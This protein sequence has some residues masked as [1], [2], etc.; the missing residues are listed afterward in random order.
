M[1]KLNSFCFL[2]RFG[3]QYGDCGMR[4]MIR[5]FIAS[6]LAVT[7]ISSDVL[8]AERFEK[9]INSNW[10]TEFWFT[11]PPALIESGTTDGYF[12]KVYVNSDQISNVTISVPGKGFS[13]SA[14]I[15]PGLVHEFNLEPSA[16]QP[17]IKGALDPVF[18]SD[19]YKNSAINI[20]SDNPVTVHAV[21]R[22][23][24]ISEGF[25]VLPVNVLGKEYIVSSSGDKSVYYPPYNSFP[26]LSG[27]VA[28]FDGTE[29]NFTLGGNSSTV[30]SSGQIPGET[31]KKLLNKGDVW[32]LSSKGR[33]A[34][35]TGSR[36]VSTKPVAVVSG[37]HAA[38]VPSSKNDHFGYVVEM[39]IPTFSWA[40]NY[41]VPQIYT[42][43]YSPVI[44][45]FAKE[46]N[47]SIYLNG[48]LYS[49][50]TLSDGTLGKGYL[51]LRMNDV[52][53]LKS[54][55]ISSDKPIAVTL[56]NTGVE[57]DGLPEPPG[58]P[59]QMTLTPAEQYVNE[60]YFAAPALNTADSYQHNYVNIIYQKDDGGNIP[61]DLQIGKYD[62]SDYV[63]RQVKSTAIL[64]NEDFP[65][66]NYGLLAIKIEPTGN[67]TIKS[68]TKFTA[69]MFGFNKENSYGFPAALKIA[70]LADE[71]KIPPAVNWTIDCNGNVEGTT[72]DMPDDNI[73]RS[74]L[75][76]SLY[77]SD[78]SNNFIK[79]SFNPIT[80][81]ET[82][83]IEW[84]LRVVDKDKDAN[85]VILFWDF[86][87]NSTKTNI[88]YKASNTEINSRYENYGAFNVSSE[89]VSKE[90]SIVNNSDSSFQI[91]NIELKE[92]TAG[93]EL[94]E[95]P[96]LPFTLIKGGAVKFKA[97]FTPAES[98]SFTDSIGYGND[99]RFLYVSHLE[100]TVGS[101]VIEVTDVDFGDVTIGGTTSANAFITNTGVSELKLTGYK[102]PVNTDFEVTFDKVFDSNNPLILLPGEKTRLSVKF[103]PGKISKYIDSVVILSDA[104]TRD[105]I[106]LIN[107]RSIE[108]GLAATSYNWGR[109]RIFRTYYPAGPYPIA[110]DNQSIILQ[111]TGNTEIVINGIQV[112]GEIHS[113]AFEF[114]RQVFTNLKIAAGGK[115]EYKVQFRPVQP[116]NHN[117]LIKY[118]NDF[119]STT[120]TELKGFGTLPKVIS[121]VVDFDTAIAGNY[122]APA[123]RKT[124]ITNLSYEDWEYADSL[125]IYDLF[126]PNDESISEVWANYGS[127][128]F[129]IDKQVIPFPIKLAPGKSHLLYSGFVPP[130]E[131][132]SLAEVKVISDA[133]DTA[134]ISLRGVGIDQAMTF[135]GGTAEACIGFEKI[136]KG[137]IKNNST[138]D[139]KIAKVTIINP[140]P[141]FTILNNDIY[142]GFT[143]APGDLKYLD[144]L[145]KPGSLA[146]KQIEIE[147]TDARSQGLKKQALFSGKPVRYPSD[148]ILSPASQAADIGDTI[149][150]RIMFRTDNDL[151][152]LKLTELEVSI[153]YN[154]HILKP[155][156][157]SVQIGGD[158]EGSFIIQRDT[159]FK[160]P[161]VE[162]YIIKSIAGIEISRDINLFGISF[163]VY[164]PND[165]IDYTDIEV[166]ISPVNNECIVVN[167]SKARVVINPVCAND[168][169]VIRLTSTKYYL[170]E[171]APNPITNTFAEINFG[172]GISAHTELKIFS[173]IGEEIAA[174]VNSYLPS[175]EYSVMLN[176]VNLHSGIYFYVIKSGPFYE[177]KKFMISK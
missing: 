58:D 164:F 20:K 62:G 177:T 138:K 87:G 103:S 10:G 118:L 45:I 24:K 173:G 49:N 124:E 70:T 32:M 135:T 43:K 176:T 18:P 42:R 132:L 162:K 108:P 82:K 54:G 16:A 79:G 80:P 4:N 48:T 105:N 75:D 55:T 111:N 91:A 150:K 122:D 1:Q 156:S 6:F 25:T 14:V 23:N 31:R 19:I 83:S 46:P 36:I 137:I 158:L 35:L 142:D 157:G 76:A 123:V 88:I 146:D 107:A 85:A 33:D 17:Y 63:F 169:R 97:R 86:A 78:E 64:L 160:S 136:I 154:E 34:D 109:K 148:I 115:F 106:C 7:V 143:L 71:D 37:N 28:A 29:V 68:D 129:K 120:V 59:F 90:F 95:L 13:Q 72:I 112:E 53:S 161:G 152:G 126:T 52:S 51:E 56:Y 133:V 61:D 5:L 104:V 41:H 21:V 38:N 119:G 8:S 175:G 89:P 39:E 73:V 168:L 139:I 174:P 153:K 171:T 69:Y 159:D 100:A 77:L 128:G 172:I 30:T 101:P 144:V 125:T 141:E 67:Y 47:T 93:F 81:G 166:E 110:N 99:C 74:N 155:I 163:T 94:I 116:G 60:I 9:Y 96:N 12:V 114:N 130:V 15:K 117:L 167:S 147:L 84:S 65:G 140:E 102:N 113:D 149:S 2:H 11:V 131:G 50:L 145:Y 44:R 170:A 98:G 26:S 165:F 127:T 22:Y 66:T 151:T 57:E 92:K 121:K 40:F 3:L 27:I 134:K